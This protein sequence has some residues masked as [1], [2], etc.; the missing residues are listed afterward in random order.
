ME[1]YCLHPAHLRGRHKARVFDRTLGIGR[2]DAD[3]LRQQIL[4]ALA[5]TEAMELESSS[6]GRRWRVDVSVRRQ[7]R[8]VVVRTLWLMRTSERVPRFVTCWVL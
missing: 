7:S 4:D 8:T 6:Y 5:D 2:S 1:D 3:W